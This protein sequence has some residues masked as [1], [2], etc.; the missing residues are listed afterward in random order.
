MK[1]S[2]N[3]YQL[4]NV[5]IGSTPKESLEDELDGLTVIY[6]DDKTP[7]YNAHDIAI[8]DGK[9]WVVGSYHSELIARIPSK[10]YRTTLMLVELTKLLERYVIGPCSF[11]NPNDTLYMQFKKALSQASQI[12]EMSK[13]ANPDVSVSEIG[14]NYAIW[15]ITNRDALDATISYTSQHQLPTGKWTPHS[16]AGSEFVGSGATITVMGDGLIYGDTYRLDV[17][18]SASGKEESDTVTS[19]VTIV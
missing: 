13:T 9:K 6:I 16:L 11:T 2:I 18:A 7:P 1:I 10:K 12:P 15:S 5:L 4:P 19:T 17:K 8:V 14:T 3:G